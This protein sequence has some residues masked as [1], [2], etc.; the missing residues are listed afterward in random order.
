[1]TK[2]RYRDS[3]RQLFEKLGILPLSSQYI[4]SLLLFVVRNTDLYVTNQE[5]HG[6]NTGYNTDLHFTTAKLMVF[7]RGGGGILLE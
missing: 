7:Q 1:M 3:C 5:I 4:F 2:S 6:I